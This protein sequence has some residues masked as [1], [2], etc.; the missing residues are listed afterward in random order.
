VHFFYLYRHFE[1]RRKWWTFDRKTD[2]LRWALT[3]ITGIFCGLVALMVTYGTKYLSNWKFGMFNYL[4]EK[5]KESSLP[6]GFAFAF[7]LIC[8]LIFAL[9]S[10]L[11]VLSEP[12]A[13]GSGIP[14]VKCYLNGL[15]VP[16]LIKMKTM[17][18][19]A[20]G[21]I[22]SCAAGLPIG[23]EGPMVHVGAVIAAE[24]SQ[25]RTL[26]VLFSCFYCS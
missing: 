11:T 23:K 17:W 19:K 20:I 15:N 26:N 5:E 16:G 7:L 6:F 4:I 8:N 22:F 14:E 24:I 18:L 13:A 21:I 9:I 1:D 3:L 12:L 10:T 25:V 2:L